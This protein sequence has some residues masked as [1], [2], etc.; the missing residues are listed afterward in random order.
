MIP[1]LK[2]SKETLEQEEKVKISGFRQF[3][4]K[5]EEGTERE[6]PANR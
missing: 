5:A 1:F 4:R 3:C 2:P 6:K